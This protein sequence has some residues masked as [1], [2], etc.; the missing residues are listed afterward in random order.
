MNNMTTDL[1]RAKRKRGDKLTEK[2]DRLPPH[3]PEAEQG[4]LGC[5]LLSPNDCVGQVISKF[6]SAGVE[7][8]YDL[9]HQTIWTLLVEMFDERT[10]I[11]VITVQ[12]RLKDR[13]LLEQIGGI[14]YLNALQDSVPSA[15]N[16]TYYADIVLEKFVMRRMV[17]S[18]SE[19]V[20]KIYEFT[21]EVP[22]L[23]DEIERDILSVGEL[24]TDESAT[25]DTVR[26]AVPR[27]LAMIER[28]W[29][30][31]GAIQ[32][33][34]TGFP[35]LDRLTDGLHNG[36][37]IVLAGRPSTGKTSLAMNIAEHVCLTSHLPVGVFSLEMTTDQLV[38]RTLCSNARVDY[39]RIRD[40]FMSESDF[41]RLSSAA[42]RL[43][44][45]PLFIDD[46]SGLSILQLRARARR[47][48]QQY[49][50][51]LFVIDYL[52]LL[53]SNTPRARESKVEEVTD[54]SNGV[55][56]LAKELNIP[57]IAISQLNRESE[58]NDRR[59]K[60]SDLRNSGAIEQD[61]DVVGLL[62]KPD[63]GEEPN[64]QDQADTGYPVNLFIAKQRNGEAMVDVHFTFLK[65]FTR[66]E[67]A[68]R[69]S[70][71]DVPQQRRE[72]H[73]D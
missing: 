27:A 65:Q 58:K 3:Q 21:G 59:P 62:Y 11:D 45:A 50:I 6:R 33:L 18:C 49:G 30:S 1:H 42:G 10:A 43:Q 32:G 4:V 51:R 53:N 24:L 47:M 22:E 9:R 71:E 20:G 63:D 31:Q 70:D 34:P 7:V 28:A 16:V 73:N 14:P 37:M 17:Q 67:S 54:I 19:V 55:K 69:M 36:E 44:A 13:Q 26:A 68:A 39:R 61:A 56:A 57:V 40:G 72:P 64:T 41:P 25:T 60:M 35:D 5:C 29:E 46:T 38:L 48:H 12:S 2:I 15:A 66:F 23:L 52:Q 8:F